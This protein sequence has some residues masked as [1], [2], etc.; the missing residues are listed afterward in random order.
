[1]MKSIAI[2]ASLDS[3]RATAL[4]A[5]GFACLYTVAIVFFYYDW[6]FMLPE[7]DSLLYG[8][9]LN[10]ALCV[11][12]A[13]VFFLSRRNRLRPFV[14]VGVGV[15]CYLVALLAIAFAFSTGT[16][17]FAYL[18]GVAGGIGAGTLM[19]LWVARAG[20][21]SGDRIAYVIGSVSLVSAPLALV[22]DL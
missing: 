8:V 21:L 16:L 22:V 6:L 1:M 19:P 2:F 17:T 5:V 18:A 20:R 15:G 7:A 13:A 11:A 10:G 4:V 3:R 12:A 14:A 9:L